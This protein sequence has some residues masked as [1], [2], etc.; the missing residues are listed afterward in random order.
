MKCLFFLPDWYLKKIKVKKIKFLK[1]FIIIFFTM[2][3]MLVDMIMLNKNSIRD[4]NE[5]INEK[6]ISLKAEHDEKRKLYNKNNQTLDS[7]FKFEE[8]IYETGK[9]KSVCVEN[10][11]V[12]IK[13]NLE[14][15]D[16][17][18]L[19]KKVE[20]SNKFNIKYVHVSC[21]NKDNLSQITLQQK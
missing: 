18:A 6:T 14:Q 8:S 13:F 2:D 3:L 10:K 9:F 15:V 21:N 17:I 16:F 19:I 7:F 20:N 5:K 4:I 12:D 1:I 11:S